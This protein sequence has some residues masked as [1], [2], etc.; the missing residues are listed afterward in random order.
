MKTRYSFEGFSPV[1]LRMEPFDF[2]ADGKG[3]I[4]RYEN[5]ELS[6]ALGISLYS[7]DIGLPVAAYVERWPVKDHSAGTILDGYD[8]IIRG[9]GISYFETE[10]YTP[11]FRKDGCPLHIHL[12]VKRR[13]DEIRSEIRDESTSASQGKEKVDLVQGL[14]HLGHDMRSEIMR[15]GTNIMMLGSNTNDHSI[16]NYIKLLKESVREFDETFSTLLQLTTDMCEVQK[17]DIEVYS[18]V[19]IPSLEPF[20]RDIKKKGIR[21]D[22]E[23]SFDFWKAHSDPRLLKTIFKNYFSNAARYTPRGGRISWGAEMHEDEDWFN[24]FN[25]GEPI[26]DSQI[27]EIFKPFVRGDY[28]A[29]DEAKG[30]GIGLASSSKAARKLGERLWAEKGLSEGANFLVSVRHEEPL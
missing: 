25:T 12:S 23:K 15:M 6:D 11:L 26:P 16:R 30:Y 21:L 2:D 1:R 27:D 17:R 10:S 14:A 4:K 20:F 28:S 22:Y 24:V 3:K 5:T 18:D 7:T 29:S 9:H 8:R 19:I 13:G